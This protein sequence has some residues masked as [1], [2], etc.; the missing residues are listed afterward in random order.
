MSLLN[1]EHKILNSQLDQ[2]LIEMRKINTAF[3]LDGE[4]R[5]DHVGHR[6]YHESLIRSAEAQE[7][8]WVELRLDIAKK[9]TWTIMVVVIGIFV[10]GLA[11]KFGLNPNIGGP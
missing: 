1:E 8:F 4:G 9:G 6:K 7:K 10:V 11:A 2:I 3:P 5:V